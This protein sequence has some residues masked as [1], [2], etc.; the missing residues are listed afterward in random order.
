MYIKTDI[1][2]KHALTRHHNHL[3]IYAFEQDVILYNE[4]F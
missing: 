1:D 2:T 3:S 4:L